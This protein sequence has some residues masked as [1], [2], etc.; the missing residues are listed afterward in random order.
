[1][2]MGAIEINNSSLRAKLEGRLSSTGKLELTNLA[3]IH[4][5]L[6]PRMFNALSKQLAFMAFQTVTLPDLPKLQETASI[7]FIVYPSSNSI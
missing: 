6:T 1:M 7:D 5:L 3:Q 4:Y 2:P